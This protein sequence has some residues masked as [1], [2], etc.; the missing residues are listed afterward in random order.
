MIDLY[1]FTIKFLRHN[2]AIAEEKNGAL[3]AVFPADLA[4]TL[5]TDEYSDIVFSPDEKNGE[6]MSFDS[7][8]FKK[9]PKVFNEKGKFSAIKV[10]SPHIH[11]DKLKKRITDKIIFQNAVFS[12]GE[13]EE[14]AIS[15]LLAFFKFTAFSDERRE[16]VMSILLNEF[17]LSSARF[18]LEQLDDLTE[19]FER[20]LKNTKKMDNEKIL[21]ALCAA[22]KAIAR[23]ELEDFIQSANR[24]LNRDT[25]R[26]HEYYRT[27]IAETLQF[28]EKKSL[29]Q[30]EKANSL[31][32]IQAIETELRWKT[33]DLITKY[34]ID[35]RIDP[36]SFIRIE[37][38]APIFWLTI[39]RR[40][41]TRLFPLTYNPLL[42]NFDNLP[43]ESCF[44][45]GNIHWVCDDKAHIICDK[46]FKTCPK[47]AKNY[48]GACHKNRCPK[49][50]FIDNDY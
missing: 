4:K 31:N 44:N 23:E 24:R 35:I 12:A 10:P 42:K 15:Y 43:C 39:K 14:K 27:L 6:L 22:P 18:G 1:N 13:N 20:P 3:E 38:V 45:P 40:K 34:N 37:T 46:C 7:D 36:I 29:G 33:D 49:C 8:L 16:G 26:I 28:I 17:N 9:L 5:K 30:K 21:N 25:K 11:I 48:C 50:G 19:I 41:L 47:C 2:G 32:K